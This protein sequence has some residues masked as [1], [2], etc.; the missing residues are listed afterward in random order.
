MKKDLTK[1]EKIKSCTKQTKQQQQQ[2][3][4][5]IGID[6]MSSMR[7]RSLLKDIMNYLDCSSIT[8]GR[9]CDGC[10]LECLP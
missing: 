2:K 6:Y 5:I 10:N 8:N 3:R 9:G 7:V 1:R 4:S